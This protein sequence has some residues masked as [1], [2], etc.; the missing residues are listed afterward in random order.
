MRR[1]YGPH[2]DQHAVQ[3]GDGAI[4]VVVLH[5]GFWR[6]RY[7]SDLMEPFCDALAE[8]GFATWNVEYRRVSAGGGYPETLED[9]AAACRDLMDG[10]AVAI[11]HSAGGHLAL[12][13]AAEGLVRGAVALGAVCD[14]QAA[15]RD[16]LGSGAAL[17]LMGD[18]PEDAWA[19]A[20][21]AKRLPTGVPTVLVHG[22]RDETVPVSQARAYAAA[23]RA[24]GDECRIVELECGHFEPIEPP[25]PAWPHVVAALSSVACR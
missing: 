7:G 9:V 10:D 5:G 11:G 19:H 24:A 16:R 8:Q 20:D 14:L 17:D 1:A 21:P 12:W 25:S 2:P 6:A 15:A 13:L 3:R 18:A 4:P 23:A 22:T